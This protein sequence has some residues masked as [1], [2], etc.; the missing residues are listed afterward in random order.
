MMAPDR[1]ALTGL[2][3]TARNQDSV[4]VI[5]GFRVAFA[6]EGTLSAED[7]RV[8]RAEILR[9]VT[10]F[11]ARYAAAIARAPASFRSY[12]SVPFAAIEVTYEELNRL[13]ADPDILTIGLDGQYRTQL[14]DSV[15]L[16]RAD[17][18]QEAGFS[19]EGQTIAIIDTGVDKM[20]PFLAGKVVAEACFSVGG[21]CPD[22]A[23]R[24][25]VA[26]SGMPCPDP[27]CDHGTHVAGI[28]AGLG[29]SFSGT[30]PQAKLISIQIFSPDA[31]GA[32]V[33]YWSDL[34]AALDHVHD[35]RDSFTIAAVNM[36]LG[37]FASDLESCDASNPGVQAAMAN[38]RS[39]GIASIVA[40]GND[41]ASGSMANPACL[42]AAVSVGA[43]STRDWGDCMGKPELGPTGRDRVACYSSASPKLSLLAPGSPIKSTMPG[44][45][46]GVRHGTSMA[47]AHVAGAWAIL[48]QRNPDATV[49]DILS[50][51]QMTGTPVTDERS[52]RVT[53]RI[54]IKDA[55]DFWDKDHVQLSYTRDGEGTGSVSFSPK[56]TKADCAASCINVFAKGTS[57]TLTANPAGS[58][59]FSGWSGACSGVGPCTLTLS[60]GTTVTASFSSQQVPLTFSTSGTGRGAASFITAQGRTGCSADCIM[61]FDPG[62]VVTVIPQPEEDSLFEK[63]SGACAG[64]PWCNVT[65]NGPRDLIATFTTFNGTELPLRFEKKGTGDG[66]VLFLPIGNVATCDGE[67]VNSYRPGREVFIYPYPGA[68]SVFTGWSGACSGTATPCSVTMSEARQVGA[69]FIDG[70][71]P[72]T[73]TAAGSGSGTVRFSPPGSLEACATGCV[74]HYNQ[75]STVTLTAAPGADTIFGGW[76]GACSGTGACTVTMNEA[77]SVAAV[78]VG[79]G[80]GVA[81]NYSTSGTG[82]GVVAFSPN[83]GSATCAANCANVYMPGTRIKLSVAQLGARS[84][85]AG[86]TG[87]CRGKGSCSVRIRKDTPV[88]AIFREIPVFPLTYVKAGTGTG[89]VSFTPEGETPGSC[90]SSCSKTFLER[91]KVTLTATAAQ[92]SA[93]AGWSGACKGKRS[94]RLT[95]SAARSV[96]AGFAILGSASAAGPDR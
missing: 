22:G 67:C 34:I 77:R 35:L 37:A 83:G 94:C 14:V 81:L 20:H 63:W 53:P 71:I 75:A 31:P 10:A 6:P 8:Q 85:F 79:R 59:A 51:M 24:S 84:A 39:H 43:V 29:S 19:G 66:Y 12:A 76:S 65:M 38:L 56:G 86:W 96:T 7:A 80:G 48:K 4:R 61:R 50:V 28:A 45:Q 36:S 87:A 91:S 15:P 68:R 49:D 74:N 17:A 13:A 21:W 33:A 41:Y 60:E 90:A 78:F 42:S 95:M 47:A 88:G 70:A 46:Y 25:T 40:S 89:T 3:Q 69:T 1:T 5:V 26:G 82:S 2:L 27:G 52:G 30:A 11:R 55:L 16:V 32:P 73:Y 92:G 18:A 57:V 72:L 62:S 54:D 23:T 93:F 58:S 9:A 44:G 64:T